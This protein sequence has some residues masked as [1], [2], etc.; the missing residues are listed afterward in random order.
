MHPPLPVQ[1]IVVIALA[2]LAT[3]PAQADCPHWI[4]HSVP[5]QETPGRQAR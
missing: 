3:G 1:A 5:P 2:W 4:E